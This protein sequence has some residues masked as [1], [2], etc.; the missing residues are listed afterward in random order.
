MT[1]DTTPSPARSRRAIVMGALGG[2][3]ALAVNAVRPLEAR[4]GVDGDVVLNTTNAGTSTTGIQNTT[5]SATVFF[6]ASYGGGNG[7]TGSSQSAIGVS[8][9]SSTSIGIFGSSQTDSVGVLGYSGGVN[10]PPRVKTGVYGI[11]T[12]DA[13]SR[14][15]WGTAYAGRGV[16]GEA[17]SG[18]GV[19][20]FAQSGV[21]LSGEA[22]TGYAL[23]T[24]GRVRLDQSAGI[25]TVAA[26]TATK[27]VTPGIDLTST[28]AVVATLNGD[29]GGSVAVKRVSINT[30]ANTFTIVLTGNAASSVKVAWL[31]LG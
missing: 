13:N 4:A 29:A 23:R 27:L 14:G 11:A 21:G 1:L 24:K 3:A 30:T 31:V 15:V 7:L 2:L 22:T 5:N 18:L 6:A 12:Q 19:R 17:T 20:G 8:G 9:L 26:G 25:T 10:P 16:F 28:S